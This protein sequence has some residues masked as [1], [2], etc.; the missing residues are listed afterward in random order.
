MIE[1]KD[2]HRTYGEGHAAVHAL[3]GVS[4]SV[5]PGQ[6]VAVMGPSGSGKSTL[7]HLLGALD[8]PTRG[9][10]VLDG[11]NVARMDDNALTRLRRERIG[12][13]FQFFNLLPTLNA[14]ENVCLPALLGGKSLA[15]VETRARQLLGRVGLG[16]RAHHRPSQLSGG[17]QQRVAIAR[18]LVTDPPILL[19]DE[20]TGNLDSRSGAEVL[21]LL[22]Q[23]C[24][25]RKVAIV[26]VTHDAGA[27]RRADR[28]VDIKD[29]LIL[30]DQ[31]QVPES[32]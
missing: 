19:A 13:I 3:R 17:E 9:E 22:R 15:S 25:E 2:V 18:A 26:M 11:K 4:L 12:F 8:W 6:F 5:P 32:P 31:S 23:A 29:G 28:R 10:V 24:D 14:V 1:L 27:A 7:L 16:D 21:T 20:P 30:N